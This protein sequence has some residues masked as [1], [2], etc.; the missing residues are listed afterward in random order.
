MEF[1]S[2]IKIRGSALDRGHDAFLWSK[3]FSYLAFKFT[4]ESPLMTFLDIEDVTHPIFLDIFHFLGFE[5]NA[6]SYWPK[7][8]QRFLANRK[9]API[10]KPPLVLFRRKHP[11]AKDPSNNQ[12]A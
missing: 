10:L 12:K 6:A 3:K 2:W 4:L 8:N 9:R 1:C 5:I 11:I 7:V